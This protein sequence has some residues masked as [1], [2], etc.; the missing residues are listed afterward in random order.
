L[1]IAISSGMGFTLSDI[2]PPCRIRRLR[3]AAAIDYFD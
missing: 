1:F 3:Y 2:E